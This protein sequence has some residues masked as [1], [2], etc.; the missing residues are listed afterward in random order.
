MC[1]PCDTRLDVFKSDDTR[2]SLLE[3]LTLWHGI[4][5][6]N[7]ITLRQLHIAAQEP[8]HGAKY[9]P[10]LSALK[11]ATG[12]A[13]ERGFNLKLIGNRLRKHKDVVIGGFKLGVMKA[14]C[15]GVCLWKVTKVVPPPPSYRKSS[16]D[17]SG[18][19]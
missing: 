12:S 19:M 4:F 15:D 9:E 11:D 13:E 14:N 6:G 17:Q 8:G 2:E 18:K 16:A 7:P 10:L 1:D 3:A 5:G